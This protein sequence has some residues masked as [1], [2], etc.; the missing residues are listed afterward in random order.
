MYSVARYTP[1][2]IETY[3]KTKRIYQVTEHGYA[4]TR[5]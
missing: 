5:I 1:L 3:Q 4:L 2:H